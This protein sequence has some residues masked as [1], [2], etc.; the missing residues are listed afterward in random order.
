MPPRPTW[1]SVCRARCERI[2]PRPAGHQQRQAGIFS[3][4][5]GGQQVVLLENEA[6]MLGSKR[7]QSGGRESS[8][9]VPQNVQLTVGRIEQAGHDRRQRRFT[10]ARRADEH[11]DGAWQCFEVGAS[12]REHTRLA[13]AEFLGQ[14][15]ADDGGLV[16]ASMVDSGLLTVRFVGRKQCMAVITHLERRWQVQES[17]RDEC[18]T[19]WPA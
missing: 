11:G 6:D 1:S 8:N 2:A 15:A 7:N 13:A 3:R 19:D 14:P 18:S 5:Q 16:M 12:Q 9:V 4:R 10:A 17:T